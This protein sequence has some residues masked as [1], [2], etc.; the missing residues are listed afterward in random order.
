MR[1]L[2]LPIQ[3]IIFSL[4]FGLSLP[5]FA[6]TDSSI[7]KEGTVEHNSVQPGKK[8][9]RISILEELDDAINRL[10]ESAPRLS[11]P[12]SLDE[13]WWKTMLC[14]PDAGWI[15]RSLDKM[16][17]SSTDVWKTSF[18]SSAFIPK[19]EVSTDES[20]VLITAEVPGMTEKDLDISITD[21]RLKIKGEKMKAA[22]KDDKDL[23]STERLYGF[24]ERSI[25]F[26]CAVHSDQAVASLKDGVLKITVPKSSEPAV[27]EHKLSIR[28]E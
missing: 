1:L 9:E 3:I 10:R 24:F 19:I 13:P 22:A 28:R 18:Q 6:G 7:K 4:V 14:D 21:K 11:L 12:G 26:P 16:P 5:A 8:T 27:E 23:K 20:R 2:T 15:L 17:A 25:Q